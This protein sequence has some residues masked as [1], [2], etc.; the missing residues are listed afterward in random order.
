MENLTG[1]Y[2]ISIYEEIVELSND[3]IYIVK[4]SL[5]DKIYIKKILP[6]ENY[7]IYRQIKNLAILN[8][9]EIYEIIEDNNK[10]IIIEEYI[11]GNSLK[12]ILDKG[13]M[14][15]EIKVIGYMLDL[16]DILEGL[17][18]GSSHIIHRDIKPSNI[19]I[20]NDGI[21]KLIDFDI[22][23]I[24]KTDKSTDTTILGT[25]GYAAPEQFGFNQSDMRTDIYS[26]GATMNILLTGKLAIEELY[27]GNLSKIISKCIE[28]DPDKRFQSIDEL[29]NQLLKSQEKY[30][31]MNKEQKNLKLPGFNSNKLVFKVIG[32][33]WY[34]ILIMGA[35]GLLDERPDSNEE[36]SNLSLALFLFSLTLLYGNYK[37]IKFKL[38]IMKSNNLLVKLIGYILYTIILFIVFG[39][40]FSN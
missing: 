13:Q 2:R 38:P 35:M 30:N 31:T 26:I 21:L 23:R 20:N 10:V 5:D 24:H 34:A 39:I 6:I 15:P 4:S 22:S 28:L 7:E 29:K 33:V 17:Y 1:K 11:N 18:S 12:D 16:I 32:S 27:T 8:I 37:D 9:P 40:A 36:V 19:M 14:L 25:Y 3:K